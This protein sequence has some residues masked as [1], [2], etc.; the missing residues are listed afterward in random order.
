M[1]LA[2]ARQRVIDAGKKLVEYGLIAR[3]WGNVSCRV[4]EKTFVITPSGKPYDSLEPEQIVAVDIATLAY[5]SGIKPSSEKGVHAQ[6]YL[7]RPDAG[8]VIHTHQKYASAA[9]CLDKGIDAVAP[10]FVPF[11]GSCVPLAAY[12]LPGTKK[13]MA[14]VKAALAATDAKAVL[15]AHHGALCFG[16]DSGAAF[17]TANKLEELCL[18]HIL[19]RFNSLYAKNETD[20]DAA[21]AEIAAVELER[22]VPNGD[23]GKIREAPMPCLSHREGSAMVFI[24]GEDVGHSLAI[25][26]SS[27]PDP[28]QFPY[29]PEAFLHAAVYRAYPDIGHIIHSTGAA[30]AAFSTLGREMRPQVDDFAQIVGVS[31]RCAAFD[32][33][34]LAE[35][36]ALC[37]RALKGRN[38]LL[39]AGEGALCCAGSKSDAEAVEMIIQKNALAGLTALLF[40]CGKPINALESKLM[41]FIYLKKYSKQAQ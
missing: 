22:T 1:D 34:R 4:D 15:M 6:V 23:R 13:L 25:D 3:T 10:A 30:A 7:A 19:G 2:L 41:R 18:S 28:E 5:E 29:S 26:L 8:F 40:G 12:G 11:T 38:A 35:S 24:P 37:A 27:A 14:G 20:I 9:A 39:L 16:P 21:A 36:A 31:A 17:E 33:G 32:T